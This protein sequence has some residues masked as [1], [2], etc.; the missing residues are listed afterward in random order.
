LKFCSVPSVCTCRF[1]ITLRT[2]ALELGWKQPC[3]DWF[4]PAL[5][6]FHHVHVIC[7]HIT[8]CA[9]AG[10]YIFSSTSYWIPIWLKYKQ[11]YSTTELLEQ[12][13]WRSFS[14]IQKTSQLVQKSRTSSSTTENRIYPRQ[15]HKIFGGRCL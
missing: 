3:F 13:C 2:W 7:Y 8:R 9:Y 6:L 4:L 1:A 11:T 15:R 10:K 5:A 14:L 12:C